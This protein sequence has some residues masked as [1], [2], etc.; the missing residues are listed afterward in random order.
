MEYPYVEFYDQ[1]KVKN[2]VPLNKESIPDILTWIDPS[3]EPST[4]IDDVEDVFGRGTAGHPIHIH[5]TQRRRVYVVPHW[6][7]TSI[8]GQIGDPWFKVSTDDQFDKNPEIQYKTGKE[9]LT[10][11]IDRTNE[12]LKPRQ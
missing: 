12:Y 7:S 9:A 1:G 8:S 2:R 5:V 11:A 4:S 6:V 3:A 10:A